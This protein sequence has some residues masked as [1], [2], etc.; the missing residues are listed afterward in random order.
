M[1]DL[2]FNNIKKV[3]RAV[4]NA[5]RQCMVWCKDIPIPSASV[6]GLIAPIGAH[7]YFQQCFIAV[8]RALIE[9]A[10][11]FSPIEWLWYLRRFPI[12]YANDLHVEK[13]SRSL[14]II[15]SA[16]SK[17]QVDSSLF[18]TQ[19][20][21]PLNRSI[22][23]YILA[24]V[25]GSYTLADLHVLYGNASN[26][27][28]FRAKLKSMP[29][30]VYTESKRKANKIYD[31][32]AKRGSYGFTGTIPSQDEMSDTSNIFVLNREQPTYTNLPFFESVGL[33]TPVLTYYSPIEFNLKHVSNLYK[34][35]NNGNGQWLT[36]ETFGL[37]LLAGLLLPISLSAPEHSVNI[38]MYGYSVH[39]RGDFIRDYWPAFNDLVLLFD[40]L[41]P[42]ADL[43]KDFIGFIALLNYVEKLNISSY[44]ILPG[45]LL[46][47]EGWI[48]ID[49]YELHARLLRLLQFPNLSGLIG[50]R[51]GLHFE[52]AIQDQINES[53]WK[54]SDKL[55]GMRQVHLTRHDGKK[56]TDIDAIGE[57][58][59]RLLIISCKAFSFDHSK[60]DHLATKNARR[61]LDEAVSKWQ[62]VK[63]ELLATPIG[64]NY[65]F[66]Q[67]TKIIAVV[68]IPN[69]IY[70]ENE[71][72]LSYEVDDL[73]RA[74]TAPEFIDWLHMWRRRKSF[75]SKHL[76]R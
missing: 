1:D 42:E 13:Y 25:A 21:F 68:C 46:A 27:T 2:V 49:H 66:S 6:D 67:Y 73:R 58:K 33:L 39:E 29:E 56:I 23:D 57:Y 32:R 30:P 52:D 11:R 37:M 76:R 14:A 64:Q 51:R 28:P 41:F 74:A 48:V 69:L 45:V 70:T 36:F 7:S 18:N 35:T 20:N 59:N 10:Q 9:M 75:S 61:R 31:A 44:P 8:E 38:A 15:L 17:K 50:N 34:S 24:F 53:A 40:S 22:A 54:P 71:L 63:S 5:K 3:E 55:R 26:E 43:P 65:N 4:E 47:T 60:E 62:A 72:S 12:I 16:K 19:L